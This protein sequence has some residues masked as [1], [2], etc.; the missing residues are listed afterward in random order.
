[1]VDLK[2][3]LTKT[4]EYIEKIAV[5]CNQILFGVNTSG[6]PYIR[7]TNGTTRYQEN[8]SD[9][10]LRYLKSTNG[11]TWTDM[12]TLTVNVT[13]VTFAINT[14]GNPYI[15]WADGNTY[16]QIVIQ[17]SGIMYQKSTNGGSSWTT[18]W[19]NH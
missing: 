14:N 3:L 13:N 5:S 11:T 15:R 6:N 7:W 10:T 16:Y 9:S 2:A 8:V 17:N 19:S 4:L 18:V 12:W 1:M